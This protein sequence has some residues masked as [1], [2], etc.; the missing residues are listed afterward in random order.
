MEEAELAVTPRI[1]AGEGVFHDTCQHG[2][3]ENETSL[4]ASVELMGEQSERIGVPF[5]VR[6]V[7]PERLAEPLLEASPFAFGEECLN[8]FLATV[9]ERRVPHVV[10]ETRRMHDGADFLEVRVLQLGMTGDQDAG[11]IAAERHSQ[12]RHLQAVGQ[13]VVDEDA[14]RK[15]EHLRLVL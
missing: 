13:P 12:R 7:L 1:V 14:A 6:N 15:R 9:A 11:D 2:I 8:G 5:E 4:A 10:G 3:R